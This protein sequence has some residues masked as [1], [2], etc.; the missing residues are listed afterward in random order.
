MKVPSK[1][2]SLTRK[3]ISF[4]TINPPGQERKCAEYLGGLLQDEGFKITFHDFDEGRTSLIA[5]IEGSGDKPPICFTGHMDTIPLG[6][7]SW[8]VDPFIG[9]VDGDRVFGRGSSDMKAGLAAMVIAS[10]RLAKISKRVAGLTLVITAGE[11]TGSEGADHL[12]KLGNVLG[13]P[14]AILVGEPTSNYPLV[15]HKGP[16]WLQATA[17]G[18]TAHG[19]MPHKGVNAIY[20]AA[21]AV[22]KLQEYDFDNAPHPVLGAPTLNVGT[23]S[24]G[25]NINSVPDLT[26]IGIDIRTIPGITHSSLLEDLQSHLGEEVKLKS[27]LALD[28]V[29]TDPQDGWVQEI[30]DIM[31]P[32][33]SKR[34]E[35]R[36][37]TYFTDAAIFTPA[38]GNPPTII[39]G[40]GEPTMAHKTD[41]FCYISKI[42]DATEA[43][44]EI[45]KR[46]CSSP[47][48][49]LYH[50]PELPR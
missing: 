12:A 4:N 33:L 1:S 44:F 7:A 25:L 21:R 50:L 24:G 36:G 16:L 2:L 13:K 6:A 41:E 45:A 30:F 26:T 17:T 3:L 23:I 43:Y 49:P 10:I 28:S 14:G 46:W 37:A 32:F 8:N 18:L 9:E 42:E 11:E 35:P 40:P 31:E 47:Q 5:R 38:L 22:T 34:P 27:L 29:A 48:R 39:L 15:G 19:S 20:K